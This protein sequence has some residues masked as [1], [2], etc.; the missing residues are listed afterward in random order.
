MPPAQPY[1]KTLLHASVHFNKNSLRCS[2]IISSSNKRFL[3]F[4]GRDLRALL[5]LLKRQGSAPNT[6]TPPHASLL[7]HTLCTMAHHEGPSA[8]F[9]FANDS[10]GILPTTPLQL[11]TSKGYSFATWLRIEE[12][13]AHPTGTAGRALYAL[14]HRSADIRGVIASFTGGW[15]SIW[16]WTQISLVTNKYVNCQKPICPSVCLSVS[17]S[18]CPVS[19]HSCSHPSIYPSIHPSIQ[20]STHPSIHPSIHP[21]TQPFIHPVIH[22]SI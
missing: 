8:F 12:G 11:P 5:S 21:S 7:L 17:P 16:I 13:S 18:V 22:S 10:A 6:P 14:L 3:H 19:I 15:S 1:A 2:D 9:D 20:P 4:V